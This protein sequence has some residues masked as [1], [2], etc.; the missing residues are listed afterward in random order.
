MDIV[1][2]IIIALVVLLFASKVMPVKGV[3]NISI[4]DLK[5]ML[6]DKN[7]QFIDVRTQGEYQHYHINSFKNI[8]LQQLNNQLTQL[9][10]ETETIIICQSGMRSLQAAKRLKKAGFQQI[11]NVK[12]GMNA[13]T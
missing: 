1:F 9:N 10:P 4:E 7:K 13:W 12:H 3:K 8:P 11:S 2:W 6:Q 5:G